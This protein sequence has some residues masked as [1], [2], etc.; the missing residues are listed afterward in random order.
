MG[1]LEANRARGRRGRADPGVCGGH[2]HFYDSVAMA[3]VI[4][5]AFIGAY[6]GPVAGRAVHTPQSPSHSFSNPYGSNSLSC[7]VSASTLTASDS[8]IKDLCR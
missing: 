8:G 5:A 1:K 3:A 6:C 7:P 4:I 2:G